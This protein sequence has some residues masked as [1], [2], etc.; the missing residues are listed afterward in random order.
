MADKQKQEA[1]V[2]GAAPADLPDSHQDVDEHGLTVLKVSSGDMPAPDPLHAGPEAMGAPKDVF[3]PNAALRAAR[4]VGPGLQDSEARNPAV[5]V[6]LDSEEARK[7]SAE[8]E[9]Q[10][11]QRQLD[12]AK[13]RAKAIRKGEP[14]DQEAGLVR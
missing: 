1:H 3:D 7:A 11:A 4:G 8:A 10:A 5:W 9:V 14:L 12:A 2:R 6:D 13:E